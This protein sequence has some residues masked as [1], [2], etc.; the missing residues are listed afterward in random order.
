MKQEVEARR[1]SEFVAEKNIQSKTGIKEKLKVAKKRLLEIEK[2]KK[3]W[4]K[5]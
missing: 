3:S 2:N 5:I 4:L 1:Y